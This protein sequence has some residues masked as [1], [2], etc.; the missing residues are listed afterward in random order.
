VSKWR[1]AFL[2]A[3]NSIVEWHS[4]ADALHF[5]GF[6][7]V[8]IE[9]LWKGFF[10]SALLLGRVVILD[11]LL[12]FSERPSSFNRGLLGQAGNGIVERVGITGRLR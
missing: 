6:E 3:S 7:I 5:A 10:L 9:T 2:Y 12:F 11:H 1:T 8:V 4:T